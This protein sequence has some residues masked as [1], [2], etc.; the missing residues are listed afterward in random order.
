MILKQSNTHDLF[1]SFFFPWDY[2]RT[3]FLFC[4][5]FSGRSRMQRDRVSSPSNR[6]EVEVGAG[7]E[8]EELVVA[9]GPK[10]GGEVTT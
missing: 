10:A 1:V 4:C 2:K 8:V 9:A 6:S 3:G 7:A 5:G